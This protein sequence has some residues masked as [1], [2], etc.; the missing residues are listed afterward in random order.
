MSD[1]F[2]EAATVFG[3]MLLAGVALAPVAHAA[4]GA[5]NGKFLVISNGDWAQTDEVYHDEVS[6]RSVWTVAMTCETARQ[7]SGRVDSDQGWS[8]D[9]SLSYGEYVVEVERP[10]WEPCPN[11]TTV[12]GHQRYRFYPVGPSGFVVPGSN[13]LAGT[14]TTSGVS[15][16]C[17]RNDTLRI[18][19]PLRL[20]RIE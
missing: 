5:L 17:G 10:N 20:E 3:A 11:G 13:I 4:D 9:I 16:G 6:V 8:S 1:R 19:M 12:T 18:E 7:C 15:G 14:D 2:L